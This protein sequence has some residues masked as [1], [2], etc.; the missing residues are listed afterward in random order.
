MIL[1]PGL[2]DIEKIDFH[3]DDFSINVFELTKMCPFEVKRI[4]TLKTTGQ[5][6]KRGRHAH[7]NQV[8]ILY[9]L[10]GKATVQLTDE[11]GV[12][13][14]WDISEKCLFI[15]ERYWIE[16]SMEANSMII[17]LASQPYSGLTTIFDKEE[18]LNLSK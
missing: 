1:P 6:S 14:V 12:A 15:P 9:L 13:T 3:T 4:Y 5:A 8:Q 17:C 18:F 7:L 16:L 11:H 2:I 10:Q